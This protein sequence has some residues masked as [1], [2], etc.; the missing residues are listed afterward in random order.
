MKNKIVDSHCHLDF[1]DFDGELDEIVERAKLNAVDYMLSI[2]VDFE[3][4]QNIHAISERFDNI[5]CTTGIHPNNVPREV[6]DINLKNLEQTLKTNLSKKKVIGLGETGL[7]YFREENNKINQ[8]KYFETHLMVSKE[9][10]VP[11][12]VHTRSAESDTIGILNNLNEENKVKG[13]IHCFTSTKE[14]A[15]AALN[16]GFYISL[17]GIITFK[18]AKDIIDIVN[19]IPLD[20]LLVETDSP[21][22]S[23]MPHR[24]KRNEPSYVKYTLQKLAEIKKISYEQ[25]AQVTTENFFKLFSNI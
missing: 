16:Q 9:T 21:Y 10:G 7:D 11:V 20:R 2:S 5:W 4:F 18:N 23:P 22:L 19:Y 13:L 15:E 25:M 12:I 24:G 3:N 8:I 1:N 14:V 17:S 6:S